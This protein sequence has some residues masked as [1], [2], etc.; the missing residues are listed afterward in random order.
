MGRFY[1]LGCYWINSSFLRRTGQRDASGNNY[2]PCESMGDFSGKNDGNSY[3]Y[4]DN[5]N[6]YPFNF[7]YPLQ[8]EFTAISPPVGINYSFGNRRFLYHRHNLFS[9]VSNDKVKGCDTFNTCFSNTRAVD[10][11][12][13]SGNRDNFR[14]KIDPSHL[15][16]AKDFDRL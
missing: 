1:F 13:S 15:S 14:R 9:H 10:Y 16:M 5:G 8:H 6:F 2:V 3:L 11:C 7:Y 12:C 4:G